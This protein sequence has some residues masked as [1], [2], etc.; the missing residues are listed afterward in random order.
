M[1]DLASNSPSSSS[2]S[3]PSPSL[4]S[5]SNSPPSASSPAIPTDIFSPQNS[6]QNP[7]RLRRSISQGNT[8][9]LLQ[10]LKG[11]VKG[12]SSSEIPTNLSE[13]MEK[14]EKP[15]K[16][17]KKLSKKTLKASMK[18]EKTEKMTSM[19]SFPTE[20]TGGTPPVKPKTN[21]GSFFE[22]GSPAAPQ[23]S[24][25]ATNPPQFSPDK[26]RRTSEPQSE[27]VLRRNVMSATSL[28]ASQSGLGKEKTKKII[29]VE[30][31][32]KNK[33]EKRK[34]RR[35]R[36]ESVGKRKNFNFPRNLKEQ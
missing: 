17:S 30:E 29:E 10:S 6:S 20:N 27:Q 2:P 35:R 25:A 26:K 8:K 14:S 36:V 28:N 15:E 16:I 3:L 11:H 9:K 7:I 4:S 12:D 32:S 33:Y 34:K 19:V 23:K 5:L 31:P 21:L 1:E 24:L 13:K 18:A 22:R